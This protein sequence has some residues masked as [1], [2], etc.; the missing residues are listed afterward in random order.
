MNILVIGGTGFIGSQIVKRLQSNGHD[1]TVF[2]RGKLKTDA[3]EILG[4]RKNLAD[5]TDEF[6]KLKPQAVVD[7]ICYTEQDA[8]DLTETFR[9]I[10][11][12][13]VVL[14]SQDVYRAFGRVWRQED[15][16]IEP[17]P[18]AENAPLRSKTFYYRDFA[19][20]EDDL[21]F[22]YSKTLVEKVVMNDAELGGTIL[23]VPMVYGIGDHKHRFFEYIKRMDDRRPYIL[24]PDDRENWRWTRGYVE[25][26]AEAIALAATDE[27][28]KNQIYNV[29][30]KTVL[31]ERK[32]IETL[33]REIGWKGEIVVIAKNLMS[34]STETD[35]NLSQDIIAD[36][37]KIR[38][39]LNF[40]EIVSRDEA[41]KKT[42][43]WERKNPPV[44]IDAKEFDYEAEDK[45]L[46]Q[47][48]NY[49]V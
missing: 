1:I 25:N 21:K 36:T 3:K 15:E 44:T 37:S 29:G 45:I 16:T 35:I 18:L 17:M 41:I 39:Q 6:E 48:K 40:K 14:S 32:W 12:R 30:E 38:C 11:K 26:V 8:L 34:E 28:A 4:E 2:H 47:L 9:G 10:A 5:F 49:N 23:R 43:D 31:T 13:V 46:K 24:L 27:R 7:V 33:A 22:N 42:I 19:E 20:N